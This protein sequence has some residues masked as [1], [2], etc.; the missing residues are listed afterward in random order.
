MCLN[1]NEPTARISKSRPSRIVGAAANDHSLPRLCCSCSFN[2]R[3]KQP[4]PA[5]IKYDALHQYCGEDEVGGCSGRKRTANL[6]TSGRAGFSQA[7]SDG[8]TATQRCRY[9][10]VPKSIANRLPAA[11]ITSARIRLA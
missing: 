4:L 3:K 7:G 11:S 1:A 8:C 5:E 10:T 2:H 6:G 9:T